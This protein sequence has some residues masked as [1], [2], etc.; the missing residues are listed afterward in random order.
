MENV[1]DGYEPPYN[2]LEPVVCFDESSKQLI[3]EVRSPTLPQPGQVARQDSEYQRNGTANLFMVFEPL[4]TW[5][6]IT[7]TDRRTRQDF[8]HQIRFLVDTV[9][10]QPTCIHLVLDNLNTHSAASLYETFPPAEAN[11]LLKHLTFHY[12]PKHGSWLNMAEIEFS[13]LSR[14]AL[15]QRIPTVSELTRIIGCF[16]ADR[17][18]KRASVNWRFTTPDARIK[19]AR[20]YP[21]IPD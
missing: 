2:P 3:D 5:R 8:A 14:L 16:E 20:L 19:L 11:R 6:H 10:P 18:A 15:D 7:V 1:L 12:T 9:Y 17:N 13:V 21:S 4:A